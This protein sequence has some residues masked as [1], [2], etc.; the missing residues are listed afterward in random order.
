MRSEQM[1]EQLQ[2]LAEL[3]GLDS[4]EEFTTLELLD[5]I[6]ALVKGDKQSG[7]NEYQTSSI[8]WGF[9]EM[10]LVGSPD[11]YYWEV[12]HPDHNDGNWFRLLRV[13]CDGVYRWHGAELDSAE[14]PWGWNGYQLEQDGE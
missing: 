3:V 6:V 13:D 14:V 4:P 7:E 1:L 2:E 5:R 12:R 8:W 11:S 10:R 9:W